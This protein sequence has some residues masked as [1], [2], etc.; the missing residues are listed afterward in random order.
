MFGVCIFIQFHNFGTP[1]AVKSRARLVDA[2]LLLL[3]VLLGPLLAE[4]GAFEEFRARG[5][6]GQAGHTM[7]I[8]CLS[9]PLLQITD[10]GVSE[11][12]VIVH[13]WLLIQ[14]VIRVDASYQIL[15]SEA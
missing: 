9:L 10:D 12:L 4:L 8:V 1:T 2:R 3:E 7:L 13:I 11:G 14:A 5:R 15:L 6:R